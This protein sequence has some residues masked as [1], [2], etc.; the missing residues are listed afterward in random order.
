MNRVYKN[1]NTSKLNFQIDEIKRQIETHDELIEENRVLKEKLILFERILEENNG[2]KETVSAYQLNEINLNK[3]VEDHKLNEIN[4]NEAI[5]K[6]KV[7]EIRL[8]EELTRLNQLILVK[9]SEIKQL[10][11]DLNDKFNNIDSLI[12]KTTKS[13]SAS[14]NCYS[15]EECTDIDYFKK[16]C[17]FLEEQLHKSRFICEKILQKLERLKLHNSNFNNRLQSIK[18]MVNNNNS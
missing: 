13:L 4:L 7:N 18:T 17:L 9:D 15:G 5:T 14:I 3:I 12:E 8:S 1:R 11:Q 16:R 2:L 10:N 6:H